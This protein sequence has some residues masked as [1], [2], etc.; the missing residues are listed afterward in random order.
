MQ[1]VKKLK[2]RKEEIFCL[3]K[4]GLLNWNLGRMQ[5]CP[6]FYQD[7][8]AL[9]RHVNLKREEQL[10]LT[11]LEIFDLYSKGKEARTLGK[12]QQSIEILQKAVAL[13]RGIQSREHE[14]KCLRQMSVNYWE[15]NKFKEFFDLNT[16]AQKMAREIN[17][18]RE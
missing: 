15:Q 13:A 4:L 8:L 11:A 9:A 2:N 1:L 12:Y 10:C 7:A 6:R 3:T 17:H 5:E 18:K 16:E 14:V